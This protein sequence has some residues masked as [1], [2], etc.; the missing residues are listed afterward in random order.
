[1]LSDDQVS[2]GEEPVLFEAAMSLRSAIDV[3][4]RSN[5]SIDISDRLDQ[6]CWLFRKQLF[7]AVYAFAAS[8]YLESSLAFENEPIE[9]LCVLASLRSVLAHL[10][11]S[12]PFFGQDGIQI[13][14]DHTPFGDPLPPA[15]WPN[16]P[17]T[18]MFVRPSRPAPP[19]SHPLRRR[20][21]LPR[22]SNR[23]NMIIVEDD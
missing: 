6:Q 21:G 22:R 9:T 20:R 17:R 1:M 10:D 19:V 2:L 14:N 18:A 7:E 4:R 8:G 16:N 5:A 12:F 15:V 13:V 23:D 3:L 11:P